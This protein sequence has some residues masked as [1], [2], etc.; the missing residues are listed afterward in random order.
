MTD[1]S[2][3]TELDARLTSAQEKTDELLAEVSR[4]QRENAE[5]WGLILD[6]TRR[7]GEQADTIRGLR[8]LLKEM[9]IY[10]E[11]RHDNRVY[12]LQWIAKARAA[13]GDN[14]G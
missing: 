3:L 4:V 9:L 5:N 1:F 13:I 12:E 6:L 10:L 2:K 7:T 11:S 14:H 8:Y